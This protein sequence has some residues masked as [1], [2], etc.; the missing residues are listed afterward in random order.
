VAYEPVERD[1]LK[2][3]ACGMRVRFVLGFKGRVVRAGEPQDAVNP[4]GGRARRAAARLPAD[5]AQGYRGM[6]RLWNW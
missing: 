6:R 4:R 3:P 1:V 5:A 2:C